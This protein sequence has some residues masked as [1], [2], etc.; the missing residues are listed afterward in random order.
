MS[1]YSWSVCDCMGSKR[2]QLFKSWSR[3]PDEFCTTWS[4]HFSQLL[5]RVPIFHPCS[6]WKG[7]TM[8]SRCNKVEAAVNVNICYNK[9]VKVLL[10]VV[11]YRKYCIFLWTPVNQAINSF[12]KENSSDQGQFSPKKILD[13]CL[14]CFYR[15]YVSDYPMRHW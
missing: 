12:G 3:D 15:G 11:N 14:K 2:N 5:R 10:T 9:P 6:D 7:L 4:T 1:P 8:T 13:P